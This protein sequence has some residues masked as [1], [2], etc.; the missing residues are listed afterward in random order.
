MAQEHRTL[1]DL[2]VDGRRD[3]CL[4]DDGADIT[5]LEYGSFHCPYCRGAHEVVANLRDRFGERIRYVFRHRPITDDEVA[6]EAAGL[7]EY[8]HET[9]GQ[10]WE[11]HDALMKLGPRLASEHFP[12]TEAQLALPSR[13]VEGEIGRASCRER[14]WRGMV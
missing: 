8:A 7:A 13:D 6:R 1:L 14:V 12:A 10:Y 9:T 11:A 3:H 5:L 4:G 2:P